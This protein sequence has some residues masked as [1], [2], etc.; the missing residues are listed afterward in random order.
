MK[1][2]LIQ[3]SVL[4]LVL[5]APAGLAQGQGRQGGEPRAAV[6]TRPDSFEQLAFEVKG[7][8]PEKTEAVT[9]ALK[10]LS[11]DVYACE[12]CGVRQMAEGDCPKCQEHLQHDTAPM[13]SATEVT[14]K[15]IHLAF[16]GGA[17]L[18]YS[19]LVDTLS[20]HAVTI[21]P[22]TF[23]LTGRVVLHLKA[24]TDAVAEV[25]QALEGSKLFGDVRPVYDPKAQQ[26]H[27][28]VRAEKGATLA[29]LTD[30]LSDTS[31]TVADLSFGGS[32]KGGKG[33]KGRGPAKEKEGEG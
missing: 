25:Q 22:T 10:G 17:P 31:V 16:P 4:A 18:R 19:M 3:R 26:I 27:C 32:G 5:L 23:P 11:F 29:A 30:A 7:L 12:P 28:A 33:G 24:S 6:A 20:K 2:T 13:F 21:D 8:T 9:A 15:A 1:H 14:G